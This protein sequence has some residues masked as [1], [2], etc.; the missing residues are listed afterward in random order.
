MRFLNRPFHIHMDWLGKS[1]FDLITFCPWSCHSAPFIDHFHSLPPILV[2]CVSASGSAWSG[3]GSPPWTS[4]WV[5]S[6]MCWT[7]RRELSQWTMTA[8]IDQNVGIDH[9]LRAYCQECKTRVIYHCPFPI[10]RS[11][12]FLIDIDRPITLP[13]YVHISVLPLVDLL[14]LV[15]NALII[16][17]NCNNDINTITFFF[18][19]PFLTKK[20]K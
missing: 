16:F 17:F 5:W 14:I 8:K 15:K 1:G 12:N 19:H 20:F 2:N 6:W 13:S 9:K 7:L 11:A 3:S 10:H 4:W 18:A